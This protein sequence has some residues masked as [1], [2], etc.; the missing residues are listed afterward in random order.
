MFDDNQDYIANILNKIISIDSNDD[1]TAPY[2]SE[3]ER[4]FKQFNFKIYND[5][6]LFNYYNSIYLIC[7]NNSCWIDC[8][9][10]WY[11]F[12]Y[13]KTVSNIIRFNDEPFSL[14]NI[15]KL[16]EFTDVIIQNKR[17]EAIRFFY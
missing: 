9:I 8:F 6:N 12:I 4:V 17:T 1:N 11:I 13:K 10:I 15:K 5:R 14:V 16:N 7:Y 3:K 2:I